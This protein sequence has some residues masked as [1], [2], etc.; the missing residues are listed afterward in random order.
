V[1]TRWRARGS[2]SCP[3]GAGKTPRRRARDR[4]KKS[5][6]R[7]CSRPTLDLVRQWHGLLSATFG[8]PVGG[9]R[10]GRARRARADGLDV[11]LGPYLHME[12]LGARFGTIVFDECPSPPEPRVRARGAPVPRSVSAS[13]SPRHPSAPT[14]ETR[15][16]TS[17]SARV[18]T[19]GDIVELAGD[20]L[21]TYET[22]QVLVDLTPEG[23]RR[24]PGCTEKSTKIFIAMNHIRMSPPRAGFA[25]FVMLS[26]R[27][28]DGRRAM[29]AYRRQREL[30]FSASGKLEYTE[31]LL[32][33]HRRDR[34]PALHARQ[35][36]GPTVSRAGSWCP[37][38]PTRRK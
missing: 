34:G 17:S 35:R 28:V 32:H 25:E 36:D 18:S 20:Y 13:G 33:V 11:R 7:S 31:H 24:V 27:S 10:R 37:S 38:S 14:A 12:H 3:R 15:C 8:G 1:E 2:W 16:S 23:A 6:R 9:R 5:A 21:A 19:A 26:A 22:E 30:A 29:A 4:R